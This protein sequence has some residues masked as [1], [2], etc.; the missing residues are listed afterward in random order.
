MGII[1]WGLAGCGGYTHTML[2]HLKSSIFMFHRVVLP[3][4]GL[5]FCQQFNGA[6]S[7]SKTMHNNLVQRRT[8]I[9]D[10]AK[11]S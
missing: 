9:L 11:L 2:C 1:W 7:F 4:N 10:I 8:N 3:E 6:I 5:E